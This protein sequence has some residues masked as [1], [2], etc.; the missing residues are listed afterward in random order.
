MTPHSACSA[1]HAEPPAAKTSNLV[2]IVAATSRCR[3]C[4]PATLA[5]LCPSAT[6]Q[7]LL[8]VSVPHA[9]FLAG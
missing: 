3:S 8:G 5:L 2:S 7:S 4:G 6:R 1:L 9:L